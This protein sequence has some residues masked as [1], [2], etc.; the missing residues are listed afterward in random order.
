MEKICINKHV[1]MF[2]YYMYIK[3]HVLMYFHQ[4]V[5]ERSLLPPLHHNGKG[6]IVHVGTS[7]G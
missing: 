1:F 7:L 5:L 6:S 3:A 2:S 4:L